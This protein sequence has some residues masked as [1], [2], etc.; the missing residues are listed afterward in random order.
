MPIVRIDY[1]N[2]QLTHDEAVTLS[3]TMQK[4]VSETTKIQD[5]FVYTNS[6]QIKIQIAPV[7]VFIEMSAHKI[8]DREKLVAEIKEKLSA[9]K[10]TSMFRHSI[11]LT[12]IPMDRNIEI[13]I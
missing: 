3:T 9:W 13:G 7:E 11:N 2:A 1:D 8:Q 12:L 6:S 10:K 5:V 4:I